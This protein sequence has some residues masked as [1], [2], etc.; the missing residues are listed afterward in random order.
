MKPQSRL[1]ARNR[2]WLLAPCLAAALLIKPVQDRIDVRLQRAAMDPDILYFSSPSAVKAL[3]LGYD[4]LL[5]DVYWMRAVQY[6]GRREEAE[7]RPVRYKNLAGLLDIVTTLDPKML[8]VYRAGSVF[9]AEPDPVGA[10]QPQEAVKLLDKGISFQP[11]EWRL[12]FEKGFVYFWY[13]KDFQKAGE[14]WLGAS[15]LTPAPPWMAGLAA[16][17]LSR[18][19]AIETAKDL[20]R[21]Q[22]E[23]STRDDIK[24]N[25]RNHLASIQVDEDIWTFEF[26]LEKYAARHGSPPDSLE[27]L[28]R[29]GYLRFIPVDPSGI[30]Y[31]YDAAAGKVSLSPQSKVRYLSLP[32]DY[33][34]S[35]LAKLRKQSN[36]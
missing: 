20:W 27:A 22:L 7:R 33:R 28:V 17:A 25:A 4:G 11:Q 26:V 16:S 29:A 14:V 31:S 24:N 9:L 32:Y 30:P 34:E 6:Y 13:F 18:G 3:A 19:G 1:R 15:R 23:G 36:E 10:G 8:D 35:F 21:R 12:W 5:A 2:W